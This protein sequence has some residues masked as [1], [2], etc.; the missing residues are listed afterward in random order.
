MAVELRCLTSETQPRTMSHAIPPP[1]CPLQKKVVE[2]LEIL[3][4]GL[5]DRVISLAGTE[6]TRRNTL[7][8][9]S[10]GLW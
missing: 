3:A 2:N 7:S 10:N 8:P 4:S 1:F 5:R 6:I 9:N